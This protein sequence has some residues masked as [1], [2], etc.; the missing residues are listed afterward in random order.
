MTQATENAARNRV[1]HGLTKAQKM[2]ARLEAERMAR[3][4]GYLKRVFRM[5]TEDQPPEKKSA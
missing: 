2:A 4:D 3:R 1:L 5:H